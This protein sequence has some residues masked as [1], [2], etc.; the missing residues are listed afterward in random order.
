MAFEGVIVVK[1]ALVSRTVCTMLKNT[2][3]ELG[4]HKLL[5]HLYYDDYY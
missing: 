5:R 1:R 3:N 4:K 2:E